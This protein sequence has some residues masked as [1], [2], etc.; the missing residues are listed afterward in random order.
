MSLLLILTEQLKGQDL[1]L[2]TL[3]S[4]EL[5]TMPGKST[6]QPVFVEWMLLSE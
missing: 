3:V 1:I 6:A 5:G 4:S 2:V